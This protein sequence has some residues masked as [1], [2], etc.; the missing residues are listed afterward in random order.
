MTFLCNGQYFQPWP[1]G[2]RDTCWNPIADRSLCQK[3]VDLRGRDLSAS[4]RELLC[5]AND[6]P[7]TS[8]VKSLRVVRSLGFPRIEMVVLPYGKAVGS[9]N[10][11]FPNPF[12]FVVAPKRDVHLQQ[13]RSVIFVAQPSRHC[14][15]IHPGP[16]TTPY[17]T[18]AATRKWQNAEHP[19]FYTAIEKALCSLHQEDALARGPH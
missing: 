13:Q 15:D 19:V 9:P 5:R 14:V 8:P 4:K 2:L 7:R 1:F 10:R 16:Q 18:D 6:R 3:P 11:T 12:R 17:R